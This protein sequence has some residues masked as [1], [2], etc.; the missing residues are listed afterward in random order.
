MISQAEA[1]E[2][3]IAFETDIKSTQMRS[4]LV[5][6]GLHANHVKKRKEEVTDLNVKMRRVR[7][8]NVKGPEA[9]LLLS[10]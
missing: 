1:L 7:C 6:L 10:H 2:F 9:I 5:I 3:S 8:D 4:V